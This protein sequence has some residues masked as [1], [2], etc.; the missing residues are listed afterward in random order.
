MITVIYEDYHF[1]QQEWDALNEIT[2]CINLFFAN[3]LIVAMM[4]G[5]F[6]TGYPSE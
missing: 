5:W 3:K 4:I 6:I 2:R 1:T